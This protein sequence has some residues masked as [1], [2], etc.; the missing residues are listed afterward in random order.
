MLKSLWAKIRQVMYRMGLLRGIKSVAQRTSLPV[1]DGFYQEIDKWFHI[2]RGYHEPWH[3]V[4]YQTVAGQR[5]RRMN[6]L[7]MAKV[8]SEEMANLIFNEKCEIHISDQSFSDNIQDILDENR[9][10]HE[11]QDS[12]EYMFALGGLI[13][14]VHV[15]RDRTGEQKLKLTYVAADCFIPLSPFV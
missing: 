11:F 1:D 2:Y 8:A 5:T 10:Y 14:K 13:W 4:T 7:G 15:A 6:T 12:L 3:K 9:F